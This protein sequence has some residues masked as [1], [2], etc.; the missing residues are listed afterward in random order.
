MSEWRDKIIQCFQPAVA[1]VTAV[2]DA[3]GLLRDPGVFQAI[4]AKGF[5][6]VQYEGPVS[7]RFDYE[8]RFRAKRDAGEKPEL[9]VVFKPAEHEFETLS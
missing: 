8:S 3:D 4:Q 1:R 2:S 6:I 9:V 7:F 5:S